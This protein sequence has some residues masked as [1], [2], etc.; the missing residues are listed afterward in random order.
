[1]HSSEPAV[2]G[3]RRPSVARTVPGISPFSSAALTKAEAALRKGR[4]RR[5]LS[6]SS[7]S[8]ALRPSAPPS[9]SDTG[10]LACSSAG[11]ASIEPDRGAAKATAAVPSTRQRVRIR[12]MIFFIVFSP[13]RYTSFFG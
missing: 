10:M 4:L 3:T 7:F 2:S 5:Q 13:F 12:E 11:A 6:Q 8:T 9:G 1:M